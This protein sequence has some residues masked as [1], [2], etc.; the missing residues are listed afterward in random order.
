MIDGS[1]DGLG[2]SAERRERVVEQVLARIAAAP[3][4]LRGRVDAGFL[5]DVSSWML[6]TL[7][8]AAVIIVASAAVLRLEARDT[9]RP[10][11]LMDALGVRPSLAHFVATGEVNLWALSA[12]RTVP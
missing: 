6:P 5:G 7:A 9:E 11:T 8:A 12:S 4:I 1:N 3:P 10:S 2:D